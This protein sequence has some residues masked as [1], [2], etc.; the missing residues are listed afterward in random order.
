M[1]QKKRPAEFPTDWHWERHHDDLL[2]GLAGAHGRLE[3][4]KGIPTE[5]PDRKAR[6]KDA[7]AEIAAVEANLER[8]G[9]GQEQASKRPAKASSK[10]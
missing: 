3:M 6:I 8:Y 5:N 2:R 4:A 10:R 7:E 1:P 9:W